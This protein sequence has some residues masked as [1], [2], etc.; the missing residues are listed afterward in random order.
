MSM[1]APNG[2]LLWIWTLSACIATLLLLHS[3]DAQLGVATGNLCAMLANCNGHGR[4][5]TGTKTCACFEGYG[6]VSDIAV[7]KAPDCSLRICP[8]GPSWFGIPSAADTGHPKAECSD[9]GFCDRSSG[10]CRCLLGYE[11]AACQRYVCPNGCSGHGQCLSMKALAPT[12][13]AFP[14]SAATT[15]SGAEATSTWDQN[16]IFGCLCDSSWSVGLAAGQRQLSEWFG[17]DCSLMRCPSGDDPM[18]A[19]DET[20]CSGKVAAGD[21][22]TGATGNKCH[23]DCANRGKCDFTTGTC[24]CFDG[25]Y[26]SNCASLSPVVA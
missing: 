6:A 7:Y 16:R 18:T 26:G 8:A 5:N 24:T 21:V 23:V 22:G 4:C 1:H 19:V 2:C 9:A 13:S 11:G 20:D 14:L 3:V 25:F 17:A 10:Q 15:Y 12:T